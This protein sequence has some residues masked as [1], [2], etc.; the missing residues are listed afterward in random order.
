M[1]CLLPTDP[2]ASAS[3]LRSALRERLG[4]DLAVIVS[5]SF[6]RPWRFGIV[7][8]AIGVAGLA[9]LIDYRGQ[10]DNSG[11]I[12]NATVMAVAD[13]L[14]AAS[15]LVTGKLD[16]CPFVLVRGYPYQRGEGSVREMLL[17]P[18]TDLFR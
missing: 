10:P 8:I 6:G 18:A 14:A 11:R 7:N 17:D 15:E 1:V 12:M 5:D 13:E 16:R 4:V 3:R 2:D 9:P